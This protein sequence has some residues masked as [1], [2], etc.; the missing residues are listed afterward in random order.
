VLL[1]KRS[2]ALEASDA[3]DADAATPSAGPVTLLTTSTPATNR[4]NL[5]EPTDLDHQFPSA[6]PALLGHEPKLGQPREAKLTADASY[7]DAAPSAG[8]LA[9]YRQRLFPHARLWSR[10]S[11]NAS[12]SGGTAALRLTD[13]SGAMSVLQTEA[14]ETMLG[15]GGI[16]VA[17]KSLNHNESTPAKLQADSASGHKA[18]TSI[19]AWWNLTASSIRVEATNSDSIGS[20]QQRHHH[21]RRAFRKSRQLSGEAGS[22]HFDASGSEAEQGTSR[23]PTRHNSNRA[24]LEGAG[25]LQSRLAIIAVLFTTSFSFLCLGCC[26]A[27]VWGS[28]KHMTPPVE[29]RDQ[30]THHLTESGDESSTS[31]LLRD[32]SAPVAAQRNL[33]NKVL[34]L[35]ASPVC[36]VDAK[37]RS[38]TE[39]P[40]IPFE[41]EW[42]N[43]R[44]SLHEAFVE[45]TSKAESPDSPRVK[46]AAQLLTAK[47]LQ[48]ALVSS[49]ER[50]SQ[51]VLHLSAHSSQTSEGRHALVL[52][53]G[54]CTA[55]VLD[56]M[57]LRSML[58]LKTAGSI[59]ESHRGIRLVVLN[60]CNSKAL[61]EEFAKGGIP[62]VVCSDGDVLDSVSAVFF[63]AFYAQ[64][65][66]G[67][68]LLLAFRF[69]SIAV[70][71]CP[72]CAAKPLHTFC[73]LPEG[74][75][76]D[77]VIFPVDQQE[78]ACSKANQISME[79]PTRAHSYGGASTSGSSEPESEIS[80]SLSLQAANILDHTH[81]QIQQLGGDRPETPVQVAQK[82]HYALDMTLPTLPEDFLGRALDVWS[83]LQHLMGTRRAVVVCGARDTT[84]GI[85][86]SAVLDAVHRCYSLQVG[87]LVVA[88]RLA[89]L[90]DEA[91]ARDPAVSWL[92]RV[93][94]AL[95]AEIEVTARGTTLGACDPVSSRPAAS[96]DRASYL[97]QAVATDLQVLC[98]AAKQRCWST[99]A[100]DSGRVL[101]LLDECDHLL[102]QPHFQE[103]VSELLR[104]CPE[105]KVLLSS[106]QRMV[107]SGSGHFKVIH[108]ELHGLDDV[109]VAKL[110][111]RRAHRPVHRREV[112][113]TSGDEE[114]SQKPIRISSP[115]DLSLLSQHP[116]VTRLAGNPRRI[117]ELASMIGPSLSSLSDLTATP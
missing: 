28:S 102:Q 114:A 77:E 108:H 63:R 40:R 76:H 19:T 8:P 2:T 10:S 7:Y 24:Q 84:H 66:A 17:A 34:L 52:E 32:A 57:Q 47:S 25:W 78:F 29:G 80:T 94:A 5:E 93:S 103:A 59:Q 38:V 104:S 64:L 105:C 27:T 90:S 101:L 54:K 50:S 70:Q 41:S 95:R 60:T 65:F 71:S 107:G 86:K 96:A 18:H 49:T 112:T 37:T 44:R 55:H 111:L 1:P 99:G 13:S 43:L 15:A 113:E 106:Q 6:G 3:V 67:A 31:P 11:P 9:S 91:V 79:A 72:E 117:I 23:M 62:H 74:V 33:N 53:N 100:T 22:M 116:A 82:L 46:L 115:T 4:L 75:A 42:D 109:S 81:A 61:G 87:G 12:R 48:S 58:S 97:L 92:L 68:Q 69:A 39:M 16:K 36:S 85:G 35:Y 14:T 21:H 83:V 88:I 51:S 98:R 110:C 26:M 20:Q 56:S 30:A 45:G 89:A 73:L